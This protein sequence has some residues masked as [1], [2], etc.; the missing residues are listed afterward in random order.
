[1]M[2]HRGAQINDVLAYAHT[3]FSFSDFFL[4]FSLFCAGFLCNCLL[5]SLFSQ[6]CCKNKIQL[7]SIKKYYCLFVTDFLLYIQQTV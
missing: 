6:K 3:F 2:N 5:Y 4:F 7:K 1:M